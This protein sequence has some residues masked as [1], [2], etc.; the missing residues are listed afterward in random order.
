MPGPVCALQA[1]LSALR[2]GWGASRGVAGQCPWDLGAGRDPGWCLGLNSRLGGLRPWTPPQT[3]HPPQLSASF[4]ATCSRWDPSCQ[5]PPLPPGRPALRLLRTELL[6]IAHRGRERRLCAG[7]KGGTARLSLRGGLAGG[8]Q[9]RASCS[10]RRDGG[11]EMAP[12]GC[13]AG[14]TTPVSGQVS[15]GANSRASGRSSRPLPAGSY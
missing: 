6:C 8:C 9:H 5:P 10:S 13:V 7:K 12:G 14:D 2:L 11:G 3:H 4:P 15:V 1:V